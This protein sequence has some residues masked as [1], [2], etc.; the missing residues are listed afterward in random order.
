MAGWACPGSEQEGPA[1]PRSAFQGRWRS[2]RVGGACLPT[3]A[4]L[5]WG[6]GRGFESGA[7]SEAPTFIASFDNIAM[8]G[9]PVEQSR[10]HFGIAEHTWPFAKG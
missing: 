9:Q 5:G 4:S 1:R 3:W 10:R 6:L 7:V 2:G 8:M